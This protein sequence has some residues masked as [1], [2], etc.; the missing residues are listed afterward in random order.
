MKPGFVRFSDL[1]GRDVHD[2]ARL[3][4]DVFVVEQQCLF[5]DL[6]GVDPQSLHYLGYENGILISCIR[7]VPPN[8]RFADPSLGRLAVHRSKRRLGIATGLVRLGIETC[9]AVYP[10]MNIR[11]SGQA[12]LVRLYEKCGFEAV[13][14]IYDE[15]GIAHRD[16]LFRE[17]IR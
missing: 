14:D 17:D 8:G 5:H 16:F 10:R 9:K 1:T 7:L 13:S 12:H 2:L 6:D 3:R 4:Q 15:D 11:L